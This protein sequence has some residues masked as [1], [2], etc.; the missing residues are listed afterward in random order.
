MRYSD[1]MIK[2]LPGIILIQLATAVLV[3]ILIS[4]PVDQTQ[5]AAISLLA[6]VISLF[7]A[8]WFASIAHN[9]HKDSLEK[10]RQQFAEERE[11]LLVDTERQKVEMLQ[12]THDQIVKETNRAHAK[13]N[14]KVGAMFT[15]AV[16]FGAIMLFSQ[17]I[18]AGLLV[19]AATGGALTVYLARARQDKLAKTVLQRKLHAPAPKLLEV[20]IPNHKKKS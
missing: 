13:A 7:G 1:T 14:L 9:I 16:G 15:A 10:T 5:A 6:F 19:L 2:F 20:D 3:F 12:Q 4:T 11:T 17:L 8:F 18:T